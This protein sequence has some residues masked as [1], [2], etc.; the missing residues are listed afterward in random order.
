MS[1][2]PDQTIIQEQ[3]PENLALF[4]FYAEL[5]ACNSIRSSAADLS[6]S[7]TSPITVK[8]LNHPN[9]EEERHYYHGQRLLRLL[10]GDDGYVAWVAAQHA[11]VEGIRT[12]SISCYGDESTADGAARLR[13]LENT[14]SLDKREDVGQEIDGLG[15]LAADHNGLNT[16]D[17]FLTRFKCLQNQR[18]QLQAND[19]P[20]V[21][22]RHSSI[23]TGLL[24]PMKVA[25]DKTAELTPSPRIGIEVSLEGWQR[26]VLK[27][28]PPKGLKWLEK[29]L[30]WLWDGALAILKWP[31]CA[32][33]RPKP[34]GPTPKMSKIKPDVAVTGAVASL[35]LPARQLR[36]QEACRR[37][38]L[39]LEGELAR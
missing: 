3:G 7:S 32:C 18:E 12:T 17:R 26:H 35:Q 33:S 6:T 8:R 16:N 4:T 25:G 28:E 39:T 10:P 19:N 38:S 13:E 22:R 30:K 1:S 29:V 15:D 11:F 9:S 24:T 5:Q 37:A 36:P 31:G 2:T 27:W 34:R 14:F 23:I 20:A 21:V